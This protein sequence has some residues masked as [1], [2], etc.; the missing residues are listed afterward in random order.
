V[1]RLLCRSRPRNAQDKPGSRRRV[2]TRSLQRFEGPEHKELGDVTNTNI[3]LGN[4]VVLTW[5]EIIALAGDEYP[6]LDTLRRD[7][8]THDGRARLRAAMEHDQI[9]GPSSS[10]LP[11]PTGEQQSERT[12]TY[13]LLALENVEHFAEGGAFDVWANHHTTAINEALRAGFADDQ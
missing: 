6:D 5:G 11:A 4:G 12:K 1:S 3:D 13:I 10:R 9:A 7:T 8:A 2:S